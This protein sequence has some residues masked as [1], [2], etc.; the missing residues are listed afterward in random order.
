MD[1]SIYLKLFNLAKKNLWDDFKQIILE[2][3]NLNLNMRDDNNNY[4]INFI[5]LNNKVDILEIFLKRQCKI[6]IVDSDNKSLLY[7]PIK[8]D[9]LEIIELLLKYDSSIVGISNTEIKDNN[10]NYSIHYAINCKNLNALKL[11]KK[12]NKSFNKF[13]SDNNSLLHLAIKSNSNEIFDFILENSN[14]YDNLNIY[15]ENQIRYAVNHNNIDFIKILYEKNVDVNN[16]D[17][18]NEIS[19]IMYSIILDNVQIFEYLLDKSNLNLQD[20][21]GNNILHYVIIYNKLNYINKIID[22]LKI[23]SS[24]INLN[25]TN[26]F[27]KTSL[28]L[29]LDKMSLNKNIIELVDFN[30]LIE[31][32]NLNIQDNTGNTIFLLICQKNLLI[33][34]YDILSNKKINQNI[35]NLNKKKAIDFIEDEKK[36][37][38]MN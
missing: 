12:Y 16:Q 24:L 4:L 11:F 38:F 18:K 19:P 22:L 28:H 25:N 23:N 32:T 5:I 34:F 14:D 1:K 15:G 26:M 20:N 36:K 37:S 17:F 8:F 10:G 9:F 33:K 2:N 31:N 6:D 7:L 21:L 30:F 29:L 3:D 13:D 35:Q 27:G